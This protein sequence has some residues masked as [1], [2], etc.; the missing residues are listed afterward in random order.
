MS[1]IDP[2]PLDIRSVPEW[3]GKTPDT[4][5]PPRVRLRILLRY[6]GR[7]YLTGQKITAGTPWEIEHIKAIILGGEHRESNMAPVIKGKAHQE[8]TKR[9]VAAKKKIAR[10]AKAHYGLKPKSGI[11]SAGFQKDPAREA[12]KE[13]RKR[14]HQELERLRIKR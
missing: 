1:E 5:I 10:V 11:V 12:K 4:P 8:K 2:K 7:D 9:D 3:I 6:D 14:E 13:R